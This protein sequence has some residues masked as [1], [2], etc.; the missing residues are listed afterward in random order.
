MSVDEPDQPDERDELAEADS[1]ELPGLGQ[2][3]DRPPRCS[4]LLGP[5]PKAQ[6]GMGARSE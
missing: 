5:T 3:V 4:S 1:V 6:W 2:A